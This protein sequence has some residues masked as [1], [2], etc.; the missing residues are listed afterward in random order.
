VSETLKADNWETKLS[1]TA[2]TSPLL[3]SSK[4]LAREPAEEDPASSAIR[5]GCFPLSWDEKL[6]EEDMID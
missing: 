2:G 4:A 6:S 5:I 3:P 1:A